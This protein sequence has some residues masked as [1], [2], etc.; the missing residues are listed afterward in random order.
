MVE[1]KIGDL[2]FKTKKEA[3]KYT[4]NYINTLGCYEVNKGTEHFMFFKHLLKNHSDYE[5]KKG[6]GIKQ[7]IIEINERNKDTYHMILK[8]NDDTQESFSWNHCCKFL[9]EDLNKEKYNL[10]QAFRNAIY[11]Q[12]YNYKQKQINKCCI[13]EDDDKKIIYHVDHIIPFSKIKESFL[14]QNEM[15]VPNKFDKDIN[16][17]V[18]FTDDDY[19]FNKIWTKYHLRNAQLQILCQRC[20]LKKSNKY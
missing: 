8:R 15:T 3:E 9:R 17:F 7:F 5:Q 19:E 18:T 12:I 13:C 4:R 6:C 16:G 20:N 11:Y 14:N 2:V 1:Y 10:T